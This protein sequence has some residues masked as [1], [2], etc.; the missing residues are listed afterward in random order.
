MKYLITICALFLMMSCCGCEEQQRT[1][2]RLVIPK[3]CIFH[4]EKIKFNQ[5]TEFTQNWQITAYLDMLDQFSAPIKAASVWK[6]ELYQYAP[7]TP[8]SKGSRLYF[9]PD[10]NLSEAKVNSGYWQDFLRCYKFELNLES[11]LAGGTYILQ[12]EC[13]TAEG[14]HLTDLIELK[15]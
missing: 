3:E 13:F 4:A 14:K 6:F 10:I 1:Y 12:A 11:E 7:R 9:W 8:D 15:L 5:L 2:S